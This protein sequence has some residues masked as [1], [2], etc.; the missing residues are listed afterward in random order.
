MDREEHGSV[1]PS[2]DENALRLTDVASS[3]EQNTGPVPVR[4][5]NDPLPTRVNEDDELGEFESTTLRY[6]RWGFGLAA[7]SF[8]VAVVT[9]FVF[10]VQFSEMTKQT[11][12]LSRAARQARTDAKDAGIA[13]SKQIIIAQQ[14]ATAAQEQ[15][16]T[17]RRNFAKEQ[18]P[19]LWFTNETAILDWT[20]WEGGTASWTYRVTNYGKSPAMNYSVDRHIEIDPDALTKIKQ[21]KM[22]KET[23]LGALLPPTKADFFSYYAKISQKDFQDAMKHDNW[24]V[25]VGTFIFSDMAGGRHTTDFCLTY[26]ANGSVGHCEYKHKSLKPN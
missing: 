12:L 16:D 20:E 3:R 5:V 9:V 13:V 17:L 10:Y 24:V 8:V 23:R 1:K 14:Q 15:V 11:D 25:T 19:Y 4:V 21:Y 6:A 2:A 22:S 26:F 18:E 7:F